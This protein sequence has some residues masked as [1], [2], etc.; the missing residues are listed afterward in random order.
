MPHL[1]ISNPSAP[2]PA[3]CCR[4][5]GRAASGWWASRS[6]QTPEPAA[7]RRPAAGPY[8]PHSARPAGVHGACRSQ[9]WRGTNRRRH[10]GAGRA[11]GTGMPRWRQRS[12]RDARHMPRPAVLSPWPLPCATH[13][14]THPGW[15]HLE[16]DLPG[17]GGAHGAP[18][19]AQ[20]RPSAGG[21]GVDDAGAALQ[22]G[23][24]RLG[25]AHIPPHNLQPFR[26]RHVPD[27]EARQGG[28]CPVQDAG[29]VGVTHH[30][31]ALW[32]CGQQ[33]AAVESGSRQEEEGEAVRA[34]GK[35]SP[36]PPLPHLT[37]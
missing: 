6:R 27:G 30:R 21:G 28:L 1:S 2:S 15:A 32:R 25:V 4:R 12:T 26:D 9:G 5:G 13:P 17:A 24:Q 10:P 19:G 34:R 18:E 14:P 7:P 16:V 20:L 11:A 23:A 8:P 3:G 36:V 33:P 29:T 31:P 22:G 37:L 35:L